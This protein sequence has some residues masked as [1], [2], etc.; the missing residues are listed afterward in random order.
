[1]KKIIFLTGA[2]V[3]LFFT[4]NAQQQAKKMSTE[5]KAEKMVDKMEKIMTLTD[6][7][8]DQLEKV[9]QN[10]YTEMKKLRKEHK[11]DKAATQT[12]MQKQHDTTNMAVKNILTEDQYKKYWSWMEQMKQQ[13]MCPMCDKKAKKAMG[14]DK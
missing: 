4:T 5:D 2:L 8:E 12:A 7:Q 10:S 9:F 11:G 3:M 14:M 1:M 6:N 13:G